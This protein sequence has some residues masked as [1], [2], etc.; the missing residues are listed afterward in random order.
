MKI[1]TYKINIM[2]NDDFDFD[3][4]VDISKM[5]NSI[6]N[7]PIKQSKLWNEEQLKLCKT[8][9]EEGLSDNQ[10][11]KM[12]KE[13][14]I[15]R[16]TKSILYK[17]M[18]LIEY[19]ILNGMSITDIAKEMN[20]TDTKI[21]S[22]IQK[23]KDERK[24]GLIPNNKYISMEENNGKV[25]R[26]K[27]QSHKN[28]KLDNKISNNYNDNINIDVDIDN[29]IDDINVDV[30]IDNFIKIDNQID[31]I[32]TNNANNTN[33]TNIDEIKILLNNIETFEKLRDKIQI[34]LN[35]DVLIE[36]CNETIK[37]MTSDGVSKILIPNVCQQH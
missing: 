21:N 9:I 25:V 30:D 2:S 14:Q 7:N 19:K 16:T 24:L 15:N 3:I 11:S 32:D 5:K 29:D 18:D 1:K 20:L 8:Y 10:I 35:D 13:Q 37:K 28:D 27:K 22:L 26:A 23:L 34:Y 6:V 17:R 36:L 33:N 31:K 4:D 12:L